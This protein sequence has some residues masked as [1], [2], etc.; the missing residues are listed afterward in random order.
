MYIKK[1]A[2]GF[3]NENLT[4]SF[5]LL[6]AAISAPKFHPSDDSKQHRFSGMEWTGD[7]VSRKRRRPPVYCGAIR[8]LSG[9]LHR[10][11]ASAATQ[12]TTFTH[13]ITAAAADSRWRRNLLWSAGEV[14]L[15]WV[16]L[17]DHERNLGPIREGRCSGW[18][19]ALQFCSLLLVQPNGGSDL[20]KMTCRG[21]PRYVPSTR[22]AFSFR[23]KRTRPFPA[24]KNTTWTLISGDSH[25]R[26]NIN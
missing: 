8:Y 6:F 14:R 22:R 19:F 13:K 5:S 1:K 12:I 7:A 25:C 3:L 23:E 4:L 15:S 18:G 26:L 24:V 9:I 16:I 20:S 21:Y 17:G 2:E 10:W 11:R